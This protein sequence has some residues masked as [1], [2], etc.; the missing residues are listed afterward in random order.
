MAGTTN[1]SFRLLCRRG[2]AGLVCSEMVSTN[3]LRYGNA[4]TENLLL[5]TFEGERPISVQIFGGDPQTM[6]DAVPWCERAGADIIDINM[7]CSVPK[8][9]KGGAGVELMKDPDRAVAATA[10]VVRRA[11]V[12]VTVKLRA[13]LTDEDDSYLDLAKRLVDAGAAAIALHARTVTQ[14][15][16]GPA[17]WEWIARLVEAVDVPVIGNGDVL[18]PG[19]A[20]RMMRETGCAAVMIARGAWG[21]PWVFE[22]AA[23][24]IAGEPMPPDPSPQERL[25]IALCHA[26]M[27][28]GDRGEHIALHQTRGQ[29]RHYARGLPNA[30]TFRGD[31]TTASTLH[32]LLGLV[33]EYC[34]S[35][36][37]AGDEPPAD[38][39]LFE[40]TAYR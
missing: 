20:P 7:G 11:S 15:F 19:D 10:E 33:E 29:M 34:E 17:R 6:A 32:E 1:R 3:A 40:D 23:A 36:D 26:Q 2:G 21:R 4:K 31:V 14:A 25:G 13:G 22:Q 9:R 30:R 18:E 24:A 8:V 16:H 12:P 5:R 37:R 27:L 28:V 39:E 35:L 38:C